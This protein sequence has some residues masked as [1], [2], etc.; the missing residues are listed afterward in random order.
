MP[1]R[2]KARRHTADQRRE[3]VVVAAMA[4]F[5]AKGL[6]GTATE[7]IARRAGISQPYLFRLFGSKLNLF[8]VVLERALLA[9]DP[10]GSGQAD[11]VVLHALAARDEPGVRALLAAA[12]AISRA[13]GPGA[14][15]LVGVRSIVLR[16][17]T[18][19]PATERYRGRSQSSLPH[20]TTRVWRPSAT[21]SRGCSVVE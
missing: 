1:A 3:A 15:S 8:L 12:R 11:R 7:E 17:A 14:Q 9:D 20:R 18:D 6:Y 19:A 10:D 13:D 2:S 4:A 21:L 16:H 5:A